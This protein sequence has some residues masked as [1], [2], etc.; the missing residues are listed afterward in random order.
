MD[1]HDAMPQHETDR[2]SREVVL[3]IVVC[4]FYFIALS[5]P[6]HL[7]VIGSYWTETDF[8]AHYAPDADRIL[9]RDFPQNL[10]NPPGYSALLALASS[11]TG[12]HFTSGKWLSLLMALLSGL[13]AFHLLRR[14][15]GYRPALLAL[16]IILLSGEFT[17]YSIQA[18]TDVPFLFVCVAVM[19]ILTQ[20]DLG[21]WPRTILTGVLSGAAYLIRYN[22]VFLVVPCFVWIMARAG[23]ERSLSNRL[24]MAAVYLLSFLLIVSPWLWLNYL[25]RGSPFF[26]T[27]ARDIAFAIYGY[28]QGFHSIRDILT[29]DPATFVRRYSHNVATTFWNTIGA[30][31]AVL[32]VGP[33]A[34]AGIILS[35]AKRRQR[36]VMILL[37]SAAV[38]VL[39]MALT[40]WETRYY[41]YLMVCYVG[42]AAYAI[43]ETIEWLRQRLELS[44]LTAQ[45]IVAVV[46]LTILVPSSL[47]A[48]RQVSRTVSRQPTELIG[49]SVYLRRVA[50]EGATIMAQK[51]HLPYLSNLR[52]VRLPSVRS[53]EE[54]RDVL[55]Q[56]T[57]QYLVY[58]RM[59]LR[60]HGQ[61][62]MLANPENKIPWLKPIYTDI[63]APLVIYELQ[64]EDQ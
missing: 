13:T 27:N 48:F 35:L 57:V 46:A 52:W 12:D 17:K 37:L 61:L 40:H 14:L 15:F 20:D 22:G 18:T 33:L 38:Y 11:F 21:V 34:I 24:K 43:V 26:N 30:S 59:A 50:P 19:L 58:D 7:R 60:L 63:P 32:P 9:A 36:G 41:F 8:Y 53:P 56:N 49:A 44:P 10:R 45:L 64:L 42:F 1:C 4:V 5:Y 47:F 29:H 39:L 16:P 25:H 54:L 23:P 6:A 55:R 51:P 2:W 3:P 62:R 28:S 31:L